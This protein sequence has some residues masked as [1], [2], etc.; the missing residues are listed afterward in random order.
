MFAQ[1]MK[2]ANKVDRSKAVAAD[3]RTLD[4]ERAE[5]NQKLQAAGYAFQAADNAALERAKSAA[6]LGNIKAVAADF[7]AFLKQLKKALDLGYNGQ[8]HTPNGADGNAGDQ[9]QFAAT[10]AGLVAAHYKNPA[11]TA[12]L[13]WAR[14]V[15]YCDH[16][17]ERAIYSVTPK[18]FALL[19]NSRKGT[20]ALGGLLPGEKEQLNEKLFDAMSAAGTISTGLK[21]QVQADRIQL[22]TDL[23]REVAAMVQDLMRDYYIATPDM[24]NS[25]DSGVELTGSLLVG[26]ALDGRWPEDIDV[27]LSLDR[28][29]QDKYARRRQEVFQ[30]IAENIEYGTITVMLGHG[31]HNIPITPVSMKVSGWTAEFKFT[32]PL[33]YISTSTSK[34]LTKFTASQRDAF[35]GKLLS[36]DLEIKDV[37]GD[38]WK[39]HLAA[40]ADPRTVEDNLTSKSTYLLLDSLQR[41]I[42][43]RAE[44][45]ERMSELDDESLS[46]SMEPDAWKDYLV[47]HPTPASRMDDWKQLVA[48]AAIEQ[49]NKKK[50]YEKVVK[51]GEMAIADSLGNDEAEQIAAVEDFLFHNAADSGTF[52]TVFHGCRLGSKG[53]FQGWLAG[54]GEL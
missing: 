27:N 20:G 47:A 10:V 48:E 22:M 1:L 40:N 6:G 4:D 16:I 13:T 11:I 54:T 46:G 38:Q 35:L 28:A 18:A 12:H 5:L 30:E 3:N 31:G 2:R 29:I 53:D 42:S 45:L 24:V 37:S 32:Y 25:S 15:E 52:E 7:K 17:T 9:A 14:C 33:D 8:D 44:T 21:D 39:T 34:K 26:D 49:S 36:L 51:F 41:V 43:F 19:I 23:G 50:L